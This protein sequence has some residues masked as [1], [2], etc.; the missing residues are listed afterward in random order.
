M[1]A[2]QRLLTG[3]IKSDAQ[4]K[5]IFERKGKKVR[6]RFN[7]FA[8]NFFSFYFG[9]RWQKYVHRKWRT[10]LRVVVGG[11]GGN[12]RDSQSLLVHGNHYQ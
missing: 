2:L 5:Q 4:Q 8:M 9:S 6:E 1:Q 10:L 11:G 12:R 3:G 7:N